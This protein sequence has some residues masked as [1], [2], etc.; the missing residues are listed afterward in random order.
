[1]RNCVG[2]TLKSI[3]RIEQYSLNSRIPLTFVDLLFRLSVPILVLK[4]SVRLEFFKSQICI[5]LHSAI[6]DFIPRG[7]C[8]AFRSIYSLFF[9]IRKSIQIS[10]VFSW[11]LIMREIFLFE[12]LKF[13]CYFFL[14]SLK[15]LNYCKW[16]KSK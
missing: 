5:Y 15:F 10:L 3:Y 2:L 14:I 6:E 7:K 1:M 12:S 11:N 16:I 4:S 8:T 9:A 13:V